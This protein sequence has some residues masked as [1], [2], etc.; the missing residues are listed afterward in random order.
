M[1]ITTDGDTWASAARH[2]GVATF[3]VNNNPET[4]KLPRRR[5]RTAAGWCF[6]LALM[7]RSIAARRERRRVDSPNALRCVSKHE[8]KTESLV[9]ILRDARTRVRIRGAFSTYALLRTRTSIACCKAHH[10]N[11]PSR[12]RG[13]RW[14][15]RSLYFPVFLQIRNL[16]SPV[17][18]SQAHT[19]PR[20]R[21]AFSA[22]GVCILASP[23]PNRG[24]GGA[25]RNVRVLSGT[26]VRPAH[27]AAGQAP[28]EAPCVP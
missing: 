12:C 10:T 4:M 16:P 18:Q 9:L 8:G 7:L 23:T 5:F 1:G 27:D 28:S 15:V 25:P 19:L 11:S 6:P 14:L 13:T 2:V 3:I 24:V 20:F 21:G 26:P 22:P 17:S